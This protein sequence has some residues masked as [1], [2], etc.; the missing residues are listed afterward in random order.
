MKRNLSLVLAI[1][2]GLIMLAQAAIISSSRW[3]VEE[4]GTAAD[5]SVA[6][7][8]QLSTY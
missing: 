6:P 2:L 1:S 8:V 3:D 4:A 5:T 7:T